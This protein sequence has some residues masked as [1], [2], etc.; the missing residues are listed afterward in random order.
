M[1]AFCDA[2][3]KK[4]FTVDNMSAKRMGQG[5]EKR[6]FACPHCRHEYVAFYTD[7]DI[8]KLQQKIRYHASKGRDV[9]ELQEENKAKMTALRQRMEERI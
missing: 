8:R 1:L 6:S 4:Q 9:V 3:C 7:P 5:I 2:G